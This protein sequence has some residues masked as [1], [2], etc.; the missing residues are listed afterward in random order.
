MSSYIAILVARMSHDLRARLAVAEA[1]LSTRNCP[2]QSKLQAD[3]VKCLLVRECDQMA[4]DAKADVAVLL[5][6]I[7][8]HSGHLDMLLSVLATAKA[9]VAASSRRPQQDWMRIVDMYL[10]SMQIR[11]ICCQEDKMEL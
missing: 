1:L 4:P 3:A 11:T 7:P 8:W 5:N 2:Q 10:H 6:R 9:P